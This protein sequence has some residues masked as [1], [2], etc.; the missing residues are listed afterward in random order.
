M[1]TTRSSTSREGHETVLAIRFWGLASGF[2]FPALEGEADSEAE[3]EPAS[4]GATP[5]VACVSSRN[6]LFSSPYSLSI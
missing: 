1:R 2:C 3:A 4:V 5:D 6:F